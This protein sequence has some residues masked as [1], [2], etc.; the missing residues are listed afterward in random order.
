M[1]AKYCD[2]VVGMSVSP[3]VCHEKQKNKNFTKFLVYVACGCGLRPTAL[4][5]VAVVQ[6][7]IVTTTKSG[8][9]S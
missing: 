8:K 7:K 2:R 3:P 4:R 5:C 6:T 1:G 9:V